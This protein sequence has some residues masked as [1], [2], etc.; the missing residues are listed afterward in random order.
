MI[1]FL[2]PLV[3][4]EGFRVEGAYVAFWPIIIFC[5][6]GLIFGGLTCFGMKSIAA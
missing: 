2:L 3:I 6:I 5:R 1:A 4:I